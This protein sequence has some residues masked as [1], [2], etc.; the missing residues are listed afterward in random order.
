MSKKP[1]PIPPHADFL[2]KGDQDNVFTGARPTPLRY[3]S[4][5]LAAGVVVAAMAFAGA[6]GGQPPY[7]LP[8]ATPDNE[9]QEVVVPLSDAVKRR[10]AEALAKDGDPQEPMASTGDPILDDV[11]NVIRRQGSVLDGSSLDPQKI[12]AGEALDRSLPAADEGV[13]P[14][15]GL[16]SPLPPAVS[17]TGEPMISGPEGRFYVAESLLRAARELASLPGRDSQRNRLIAAMREQATVLMIDEF[18]Q[19]PTESR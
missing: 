18:S 5:W 4:R 19:L 15:G 10:I 12:P 8:P 9:L 17:P 6:V 11:L 2:G 7:E 13:L 1:H 14:R 16:L 3:P